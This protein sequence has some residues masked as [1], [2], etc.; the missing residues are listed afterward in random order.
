MTKENEEEKD[1]TAKSEK[2]ADVSKEEETKESEE[3]TEESED[4]EETKKEEE[5]KQDWKKR[6]EDERLAREKA[7]RA[8]AQKRYQSKHPKED[9]EEVEEETE[10]KPITR[11]ELQAVLREERDTA[12]KEAFAFQAKEL[13][14]KITETQEEADAVIAIYENRTLG[15]TLEQQIQ[16]AY[17]IAHGPR[18]LAKRDELRRSLKSKDTKKSGSNEDTHR[19]EAKGSEPKLAAQDK[20]EYLRLGF[21]WN[22]KQWTKKL[23]SGKTLVKDPK[24]G[25]TFTK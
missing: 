13:A 24:T 16:E 5:P 10:E 1:E 12:R 4:T 14:K 8:L 15:G 23:A 18:L 20:A 22:G 2:E 19:D 17:F 6:A 11:A 21:T 25:K 9:E 3:E 7:E